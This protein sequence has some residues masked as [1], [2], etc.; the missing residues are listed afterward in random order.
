MEARS[1]M[2]SLDPGFPENVARRYVET[3]AGRT[4]AY[5]RWTGTQYITVREPLTADVVLAAVRDR[6]P[7]GGYF[8]MPDNRSHVAALDLDRPDGWDI[9]CRVG[10]WLWAQVGPAYVERSRAGRAHLWIVVGSD[11]TKE[12]AGLPGVV[13]RF[14][15][16]A[17]LAAAGL[18]GSPAI[19]LRP[20]SDR[21]ARPDGL[22]H[23]LRLPTMPHKATGERHPLCDPRTGEPIGQTMGEMLAVLERA[24]ASRMVELAERYRPPTSSVGEGARQFLASKGHGAIDRFNAH[25]GVCEVLRREY[26]VERAVPGRTIRCPCHDDRSP[27]LSIARDDTRVWCHAPSCE[28]SADG[29]GQD[30]YGLWTLAKTRTP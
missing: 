30:A 16:R 20:G 24:S 1:A 7:I 14:A 4:D 8:L 11:S 18:D 17:A 12:L 19:E 15:L 23:A 5:V 10:K 26:S 2:S 6:R 29:R 25:V 9:A 21:L 27:S 28:L 3:F 13:L 22:G